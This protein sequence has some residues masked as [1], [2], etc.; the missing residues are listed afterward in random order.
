MPFNE[1]RK[2]INLGGTSSM[3]S[4][5]Q[6]LDEVRRQRLTGENAR[7]RDQA[8]TKLQTWWRKIC[9]Q[10]STQT[11]CR[12][13]FDTDPSTLVALRSLVLLQDDVGRMLLWST[14]MI[15]DNGLLLLKRL[16]SDE[17]SSWLILIRQLSIR[18]LKFMANSPS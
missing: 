10:K 17:R 11:Q 7:K 16:A 6:V 4:L 8:A 18:F 14:T 12:L 2:P 5:S 3:I 9:T 13:L 15:K 1:E